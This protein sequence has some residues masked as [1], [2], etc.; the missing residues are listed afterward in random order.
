MFVD[1]QAYAWIIKRVEERGIMV[2]ENKPLLKTD[3]DSLVDIK[4]VH[5][6]PQLPQ[7]ERVKEFVRQIKDPYCF[8]DGN[9]IVKIRFADTQITLEERLESFFSSL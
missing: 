8:R 3:I 5:I 1:I 7:N 9:V 2:S 6:D 4:D